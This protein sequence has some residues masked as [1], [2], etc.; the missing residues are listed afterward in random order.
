VVVHYEYVL[1]TGCVRLLLFTVSTRATVR[2][3]TVLTQAGYNEH[4]D[5]SSAHRLNS[6]MFSSVPC[7]LHTQTC[8]SLTA[9]VTSI[10][11]ESSTQKFLTLVTIHTLAR[12]QYSV[13]CS[14][15]VTLHKAMKGQ[16]V[17]IQTCVAGQQ[18][19][20]AGS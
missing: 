20:S 15:A 9:L 3:Y 4:S 2:H 5:G 16:V 10:S 6:F 12:S 1:A 19:Y 7:C 17:I 13:T 11:D 18:Q 8:Q 14:A